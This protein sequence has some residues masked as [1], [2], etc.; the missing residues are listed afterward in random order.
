MERKKLKHKEE[1]ARK[2]LKGPIPDFLEPF[3]GDQGAGWECGKT[4]P[5]IYQSQQGHRA[6]TA[7]TMSII[8]SPG[9]KAFSL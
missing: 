7:K 2:A 3:H 6:G 1:V 4:I 8:I 5:L 9:V